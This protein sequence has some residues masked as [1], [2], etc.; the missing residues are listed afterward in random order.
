MKK[1]TILGSSGSIGTQSLEVI[2]EQKDFSAFALS[3]NKNIDLLEKQVRKYKP[4]YA[5]VV[6]ENLC[7]DFKIKV[8]D[9]N[10]KVL[11]GKEG[12]R[13][14]ASLPGSDTVVTAVVGIAGLEPTIDAV[15]AKKR[16][17]LANKETLVTAGSIVTALAK[18]NGSE[19]IPV[20]SEHSAI[21]QSLGERYKDGKNKKEVKNIILTAS[22]GPFYKKTRSDLLNVTVKDAL[23][24]PNWSM[25]A[26]ITIDSAT[27]M[28]KGLEVIEATHLFGV[29]AKNVKV[30]VHRQSI[31][32][33]MVELV[34][35]GVIAQLGA[36]DM[37]LP[38]QYAIT[39]PQRCAM[40]KNEL[41][42]KKVATLTFD[43]PD[44]DTFKALALSY[45]A[46]ER[47]GN[48]PVI[49]NGA[50]EACVELFLK[51]KIK[52]LDIADLVEEAIENAEFQEI[53]TVPDVLKWDNW[54]REYIK[55][56]V[57]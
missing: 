2:D 16:I 7:R 28:N 32:H 51:E 50:N 23:K 53:K 19:I 27:L 31:V 54:A 52:F 12:M 39:Y 15:K 13:E 18:E 25:G 11:S 35:N 24:H 55:S 1:I 34:D 56:V 44:M 42:L 4:A 10:V 9:T 57:K 45:K 33:S 20:D 21:F 5:C 49:L 37:K 41:D 6:D 29:S 43:E 46:S 30:L 48:I 36:P 14:I 8:K 17:A 47:G 40:T 38:I 3:V 22:G 26:K